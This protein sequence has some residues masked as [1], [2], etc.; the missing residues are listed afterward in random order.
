MSKFPVR[1]LVAIPL[2]GDLVKQIPWI[3]TSRYQDTHKPHTVDEYLS[4]EEH[5]AII[6]DLE[7]RL[8]IAT[9]ALYSIEKEGYLTHTK[10]T[11]FN[12]MWNDWIPWA[13]KYA[14]DALEKIKGEAQR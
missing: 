10:V 6:S 3:V 11:E 4:L 8:Q 13:R 7:K 2:M 1:V 9:E 5:Q 12:E 14:K